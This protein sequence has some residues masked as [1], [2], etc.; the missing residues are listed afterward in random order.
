MEEREIDIQGNK[1]YLG[2]GT[3]MR[4][5]IEEIA[6]QLNAIGIYPEFIGTQGKTIITTITV[7]EQKKLEERISLDDIKKAKGK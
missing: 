1:V 4:S 7:T 3:Y 5:E 2:P 6:L